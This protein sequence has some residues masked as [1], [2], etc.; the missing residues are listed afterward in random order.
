MSAFPAWLAGVDVGSLS[1]RDRVELISELERVKGS[2]SAAQARATDALR[3]SRELAAPQDAARSVGSVVALARRGSP[4]PGDRF[5]GL[6]RALVREMPHLMAAL[7]AGGTSERVAVA[8]VAATA[9]SSVDDRAEVD[10]RLAPVVTR[11]GV[12][13]AAQAATRVAAELDAASV[14]ARREAAVRSRRVSVRPAPDGMAYLTVLGPL[15]DVVGTHA[16][17]QAGARAVVGG[18]RPGEPPEG[19]GVGAVAADTALRLLSGRAVGQPQPV[20]VHLVVTDRALLGT[21]DADRSVVEPARVPGHGSVP[22]PVARVWLREGL[23]GPPLTAPHEPP[24]SSAARVWVRRRYTTPDGRDLVAMDSRRRCFGGM[25]RRMLVL[26]DDVC[27][28]PWCEAPIVHAGHATPVRE[29]SATSFVEGNGK[30]ARCNH[31]KEAPGWR[32]RSILPGDPVDTGATAHDGIADGTGNGQGDGSATGDVVERRAVRITTPL[33]H[34]YDSEPPP[35]LGWASGSHAPT[36]SPES[37]GSTSARS[38]AAAAVGASWGI[39]DADEPNQSAPVV[40]RPG[41]TATTG[42]STNWSTLASR[43]T[44]LAGAGIRRI[45]TSV[46]RST[47]A[48][49][50]RIAPPI[51]TRHPP[52]AR[53]LRSQSTPGP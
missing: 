27:T 3:R 15:K 46:D 4:T 41:A 44:G 36:A 35:L 26:R 33:G 39:V 50:V 28:T 40:Q 5:V 12:R 2:A 19:R 1:D 16:A 14:V 20:E 51:R 43:S 23:R 32:A 24:S 29:L 25:L 13:Q 45:P 21:G 10:R 30:C 22:A 31:V 38:S 53:T 6:S 48:P 18:Q 9:T 7:T 47:G 8:F 37:Q 17:L 42:I 11:L 49:R 52:A 34:Q